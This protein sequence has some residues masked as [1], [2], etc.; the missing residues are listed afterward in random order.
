MDTRFESVTGLCAMNG[1]NEIVLAVFGS[2]LNLERSVEVLREAGYSRDEIS[3]LFRGSQEPDEWQDESHSRG[4]TAGAASGAVLGGALGWLVGLGA[5]AIPG[6][7]LMMA[8][9][10]MGLIA[11]AGVGSAVGGFAGVLSGL[12]IKEP[13]IEDYQARLKRGEVLLAVHAAD[14]ARR[15]EAR[16]LLEGTEAER[17]MVVT[18]RGQDSD[19]PPRAGNE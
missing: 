1:D 18:V 11:G 2:K 17:V 19:V 16:T 9:P 15:E 7:G 10:A 13:D 6:V 14:P 4:I 12:G 5:V 3:I 8:G